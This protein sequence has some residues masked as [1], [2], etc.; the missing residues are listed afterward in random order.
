LKYACLAL[1][2]ALTIFE[3]TLNDVPIPG[4]TLSVKVVVIRYFNV[5][6]RGIL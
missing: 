3:K 1:K 5:L 6:T 2:L 4:Q